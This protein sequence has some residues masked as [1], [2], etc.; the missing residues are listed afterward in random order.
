MVNSIIL[1]A[2]LIII[3]AFGTLFG[4]FLSRL[5]DSIAAEGKTRDWL[6]FIFIFLP[7]AIIS[8]IMIGQIHQLA[9][10]PLNWLPGLSIGIR[11]TELAVVFACIVACLS[12]LLALFSIAYMRYDR[13]RSRY[14]FF[15]Q[16]TLSAMMVA[17]FSNNLFW[18]F[19]GV[20]VA[21]ISA[22]FLISHWHQKSG[23]EGEKT[24]KAAIR[25]LIM[26]VFSDIF[27]LL[28]FSFLMFSFK[29][30]DLYFLSLNW[31]NE[32]AR[33]IIGSSNTTRLLIKILIVFGSLI[34]SAQF[35][36]LLWTLSG[37]EKD[38]DLAKAPL[39]AAIYL[40]SVIIGNLGL[41]IISILYPLFSTIGFESETGLELFH[42]SPFIIM[43]WFAIATLIIIAGY[44][45]TTNNL[46]RVVIG[47]ATAQVSFSFLGLSASSDLGLT[48]AIFQL[49]TS[50]PICVAIALIFG[51]V[52]DS[53]RIKDISRIKGFKGHSPF[54]YWMGILSIVSFAGIFPTSTYFSKDMLFEALNSSSIPSSIGLV[55]LTLI[56]NLVFI[57]ALV[58]TFLKIFHGEMSDQYSTRPLRF[59][60]VIGTVLAVGWAINSGLVLLFYG[61]PSSHMTGGIL[62]T[63]IELP[64]DSPIFSN[65]ILSPIVL[66]LSLA[67]LIGTFSL[68]YDGK[69]SILERI[70][71][72]KFTSFFRL[73][74]DNGLYIDNIYEFIIFQPINFLSKFLTW[75]RIKA[76]FIS[77]I[78]AILSVILLVSIF[79]LIGGGI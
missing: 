37:K 77:I 58:K 34:K 22:F 65:W 51:Q 63:R 16:L 79:I 28:G 49:L 55:I 26:S 44:I 71:K 50:T 53:L 47:I 75:I 32:P 8:F 41:Y 13:N 19:G 59:E 52:I 17:I 72:S 48:A 20:E 3:P 15:F 1:A 39:P 6:L 36:L 12:A 74:F 43:G 54:L 25:F 33:L 42:N 40:I 24:S 11:T 21:S 62:G 5:E 38:N 67:I 14:W 57:F 76:P 7:S 68:Y 70:N 4:L 78:W 27:L 29:T 2:L 73:A 56:M 23:E 31:F 61:F 46:N 60:S 66:I 9:N 10:Y 35:P 69:G 45:L 30:S 64:Y 18:L